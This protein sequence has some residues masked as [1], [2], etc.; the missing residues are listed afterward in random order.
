MWSRRPCTLRR[1]SPDTFRDL[2]IAL[3]KHNSAELKP[4]Q[5]DH[6]PELPMQRLSSR[7][8]YNEKVSDAEGLV[9]V[10]GVSHTCP[11]CKTIEPVVARMM[12]RY[13]DAQF[14]RYNVEDA[15]DLAHELGAYV[16]PK[17]S[18]FKDGMFEES[19][20]GADSHALEKAIRES[21]VGTIV[22][23]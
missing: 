18:I 9:I 1:T 22:N 20:T 3:L 11:S 21:Y 7:N 23:D 2:K 6:K 17:F 12:R 15:S 4:E 19:V 5:D 8:D 14:Y 10:E 16:V 13:P